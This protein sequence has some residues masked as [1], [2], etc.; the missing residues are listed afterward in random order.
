MSQ[1]N[2]AVT[3]NEKIGGPVTSVRKIISSSNAH[4]VDCDYRAIMP[5][6]NGIDLM[7]QDT[8]YFKNLFADAKV[9]ATQFIDQHSID[10][11]ILSGN[12]ANVDPRLF[13]QSINN[14]T[15][16]LSRAIAEMALIHCALER[17]IPLLGICGG[18]QIM[19]VFLGGT[20]KDLTPQDL[21]QHGFF[22]YDAILLDPNSMLANIMNPKA[23]KLIGADVK[24]CEDTFNCHY[25][26]ADMVGGQKQINNQENWL[27]PVGSSCE[28]NHNIEAIESQFGAPIFATQFHPEVPVLG[29]QVPYLP[30]PLTG[31]VYIA[32]NNITLLHNQRIFDA[33]IQAAQTFHDKRALN[34]S[35]RSLFKNNQS[36]YHSILNI[37]HQT[38]ENPLTKH[39]SHT[40][41]S[42]FEKSSLT[43]AELPGQAVN[44]VLNDFTQAIVKKRLALLEAK[45]A[46]EAGSCKAH[47]NLRHIF[48]S[49]NTHKCNNQK[50]EIKIKAQ[51]RL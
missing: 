47:F 35:I 26:V 33:V 16:D 19:N 2:V 18:L 38:P 49:I 4:L 20:I 37:L 34:E 45:S 31:D 5:V 25:Q 43:D 23:R 36:S 24:S 12:P 29:C 44:E 27:K 3:Y 40:M 32:R 9:N 30:K 42:A 17:G 48:S 1:P 41:T 6:K 46:T 13:G 11:V 51:Q 28:A 22:K 14:E 8:E 15:I 7:Y 10:A 39:P 21:K 50:K